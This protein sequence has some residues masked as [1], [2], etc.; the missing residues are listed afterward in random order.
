MACRQ[1]SRIVWKSFKW[2]FFLTLPL[3][4]L[5]IICGISTGFYFA[6]WQDNR[7]D[8]N[9]ETWLHEMKDLANDWGS[10][11]M[12]FR[13]Y[14]DRKNDFHVLRLNFND[15]A[16]KLG[17]VQPQEYSDLNT[18]I[19][20]YGDLETLMLNTSPECGTRTPN[21]QWVYISEWAWPL[22]SE[23]DTAFEAA[24]QA[25]YVPSTLNE[26]QL[27]YT[28]CRDTVGFLCGVW[29]VRPPALLHF[30]INDSPP[31]PEDIEPGL[32]YP[33]G[34]SNLRPVTVRVIEFPLKD[35]YT[36][37]PSSVFP[38]PTEQMLAMM[39]GDK[40]Y[41][42]FEPWNEF[43]QTMRRFFE[44]IDDN[45]YKRKGT[46]LYYLGIADDW[47]TDHLEKPLGLEEAAQMVYTVSFLAT[48]AVTNGLIV[49][50]WHWVKQ[51]FLDAL[52][53]P[54]RG[55]Q[56]LGDGQKEWNPW[57]DLMDMSNAVSQVLDN[58]LEKAELEKGF[59]DGKITTSSRGPRPTI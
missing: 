10:S 16:S 21:E 42:Q 17:F 57:D 48:V 38:G 20:K 50:P 9:T 23:W 24:V 13:D 22:L 51:S 39:R 47:T 14:Q 6:F 34:L 43:E 44:Y 19:N 56:I 59:S 11:E 37:L 46:F 30:S 28:Q 58:V 53:Y 25:G 49:R 32:T 55:D 3:T 29:G 31:R 41:E 40:L 45:F 1:L 7:I 35:A 36:G 18:P 12:T 54:K 52:G 8:I 33:T 27:F 15:W 26:T 2:F 5:P 4:A